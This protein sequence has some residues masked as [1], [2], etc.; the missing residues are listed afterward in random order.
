MTYQRFVG[1]GIDYRPCR[2]GT[3]KLTFRGPGRDLGGR[4]VAFLGSTETYG[5]FVRTPFPEIVGQS[6]GVTAVNLGCVNAGLD[7]YVDD[8]AVG[9]VCRGARACVVQAMGA[10]KLSNPFY[11]VH[12]RRNDRV[13][14][15]TGRLRALYPEVDFAEIHFARHLVTT[16]ADVDGARFAEVRA[17]LRAAWSGRMS[18]LVAASPVPVVLLW[19]SDRTP[20]DPSGRDEPLFVT[21]AMIDALAPGLAGSIEIVTD[22]AASGPDEGMICS[23]LE[24]P[25]A[26]VLPGPA[27]HRE[28]AAL[29][30]EALAALV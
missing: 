10:H 17:G 18:S 2:Y 4:Y 22:P 6:L 1:S 9:A 21:R 30:S 15:P 8:A 13:V 28:V 19:L 27:V 11:T 25:A 23:D 12:A 16:L 14:A 3:S 5:K 24:R 29:L 20:D 26:A 7:A